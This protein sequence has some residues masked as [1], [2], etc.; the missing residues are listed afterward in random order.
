MNKYIQNDIKGIKAEI[1][2]CEKI[3]KEYKEAKLPSMIGGG[4]YDQERK[5]M[6]LKAVIE[7]LEYYSSKA[8]R[9]G[10]IPFGKY[11]DFRI[12]CVG[13][14]LRSYICIK[15]D[16]TSK[17]YNAVFG[18]YSGTHEFIDKH[19]PEMISVILGSTKYSYALGSWDL[20]YAAHYFNNFGYAK[21]EKIQYYW[22]QKELDKEIENGKKAID[23]FVEMSKKDIMKDVDKVVRTYFNVV[24]KNNKVE[25]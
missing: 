6:Y 11:L 24:L 14:N 20:Q 21:P 4:D 25:Y 5:I 23:W 12:D 10:E 15:R 7:I 1:E 18:S 3:Q 17:L 19:F 16:M 8:N 13:H 2:L 9:K 22:S